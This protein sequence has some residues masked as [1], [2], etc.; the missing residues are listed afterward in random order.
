MFDGYFETPSKIAARKARIVATR[1]LPPMT[2]PPMTR[3]Q[4]EKQPAA[5][6]Y[7][8]PW[9][10]ASKPLTIRIDNTYQGGQ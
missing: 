4:W 1:T 9:E 10:V 8:H 6:R 5:F 3:S 2:L 7:F